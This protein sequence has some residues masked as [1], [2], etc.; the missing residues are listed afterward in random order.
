MILAKF[1]RARTLVVG[2]A[3]DMLAATLKWR[4]EMDIDAIMKEEFDQDL[5]GR[6]GKVYGKDK[7]G[8]PIAWNL[9]GEVKD[10]KAVFGDTQKFIRYVPACVCICPRDEARAARA[11]GRS[12]VDG[13]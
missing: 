5:F 13:C 4:A 7:E 10:M 3:A 1:V 9:Y 11:L 8:R 6:L 12:S 2:D